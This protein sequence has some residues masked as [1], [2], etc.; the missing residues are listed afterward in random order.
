MTKPIIHLST[1]DV[2]VLIDTLIETASKGRNLTNTEIM[3]L[4]L[5]LGRCDKAG[6][7]Y[8]KML[9]LLKKDKQLRRRL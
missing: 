7:R 2:K 9:S 8:N 3:L 6:I 1:K 4:T 5:V